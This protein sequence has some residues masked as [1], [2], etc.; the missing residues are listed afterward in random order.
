MLPLMFLHYQWSSTY[1]LIQFH[2][3]NHPLKNISR[4]TDFKNSP[5]GVTSAGEMNWNCEKY[6]GPTLNRFVISGLLKIHVRR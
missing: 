3:R 6:V 5:R 4:P 2:S 1:F